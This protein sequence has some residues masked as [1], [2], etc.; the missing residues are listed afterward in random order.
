M[1]SWAIALGGV[2]AIVAGCGEE[3][4]GVEPGQSMADCVAPEPT[5]LS[6]EFLGSGRGW[7]E[8][9]WGSTI[10]LGPAR[11]TG[12]ICTESCLLEV[13]A[14]YPYPIWLRAGTT[15][16]LTAASC[17][18]YG[19]PLYECGL[20]SRE[21]QE[22]TFT[23]EKDPNELAT[24]FLD[25][26]AQALAFVSDGDLVVGTPSSLRRISIE[27]TQRWSVPRAGTALMAT[28]ATDLIVL[29]PDVA[30]YRGD[31]SLAWDVPH[32]AVAVATL[33]DGSPI[34]V[35]TGGRVI[36]LSATDGSIIW[37]SGDVGATTIAVD[38][39]GT[40][41]AAAGTMV[42]RFDATGAALPSWQAPPPSTQIPTPTPINHLAFDA[43][44][45]L[46][47][48]SP[49][50]WDSKL[51]DFHRFDPTGVATRIFARS[52]RPSNGIITAGNHLFY[53]GRIDYNLI[54]IRPPHLELVMLDPTGE[55]TWQQ[56]QG[57]GYGHKGQFGGDLITP[58]A[59]ACRGQTCAVSG[60][61]EE[62]SAT[63]MT[64]WVGV[65][66]IL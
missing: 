64:N 23:F 42:L 33:P 7:V 35:T 30:A 15:Q 63:G 45:Q 62:P 58:H 14:D 20:P 34:I 17:N 60:T 66:A 52:T 50:L 18:Q 31:G 12:L 16:Q 39:A 6:I 11:G 4:C 2:V 5:R 49:N 41:A 46:V 25:S 8:V 21:D 27:G 47:M 61:Y 19:P 55:V 56:T 36:A 65:Y 28:S 1:A 59:A 10:G 53:W 9:I 54:P 32:Q 24:L 29:G 13:P 26:S 43:T 57:Y 3:P 44:N 38:A 48:T 40:V 51:L 22:L 37:Q